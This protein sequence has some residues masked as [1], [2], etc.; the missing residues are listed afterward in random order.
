MAIKEE[1]KKRAKSLVRRISAN[2]IIA[3][4]EEFPKY[5]CVLSLISLSLLLDDIT[6]FKRSLNIIDRM[7][8]Q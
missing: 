5:S 7:E 6:L 2:L 1:D 4:P 8:N 3:D